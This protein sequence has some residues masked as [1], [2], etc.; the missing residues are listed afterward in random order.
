MALKRLFIQDSK[1]CCF[2]QNI[3]RTCLSDDY[4]NI[5][6]NAHFRRKTRSVSF[7]GTFFTVSYLNINLKFCEMLKYQLL[8]DSIYNLRDEVLIYHLFVFFVCRKSRNFAC[9][10]YFR[11]S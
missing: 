5:R 11:H 10:I 6:K 2:P 7:G 9:G 1:P 3:I 8:F 4:E